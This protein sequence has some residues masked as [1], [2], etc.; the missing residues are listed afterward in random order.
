MSA[1]D[2]IV[3]IHGLWVTPRSWEHW[4]EHYERR[5]FRVLAP[6]YPGLEVEVEALNADPAPIEE[7]TV[8]GDPRAP[9]GPRAQ[10]REA[11]DPDRPLG[12]RDLR[13]AAARPRARRR[14]RGD[15]LGADRGR[16]GGA[17]VAG[18]GRVPGPEEPGQPPQGRAVHA[19]AVAVR[20]HDHVQRRG[21]RGALQALPR[22]R[23]RAARVGQRAGEHPARPPGDLGGLQERRP[24]AAAVHR[25]HRRHT[26]A[27]VGPALERQALQVGDGHR[28]HGV[29]RSASAA[30]AGE[31]A[32]D[33]RLRAR[34]GARARVRHPEPAPA[35]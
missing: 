25:R 22:P 2:T 11:A 28:D 6:A 24:R 23:P 17:A 15:Q 5:G 21:D 19:L 18:E 35:A 26:D 20:V 4:I 13:P 3:L 29:R 16:A 33:R 9:R 34:L 30:G 8:D 27:A 10:P 1:P 14:R 12:R 7:L 32:G 31:L